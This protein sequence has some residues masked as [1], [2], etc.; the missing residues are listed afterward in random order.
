MAI[1]QS[2]IVIGE[3]GK[4]AAKERLVMIKA[5]K[6]IVVPYLREQGFKGSFPHYRRQNEENMDLITFQFNRYGGSF[7]VILAICPIE[8]L[9]MSWGEEIPANKVTAHDVSV[10]YRYRLT[11]NIKESNETWFNYENAKDE[12]DF[13]QVASKV[14]SLLHVSDRNWIKN[15]FI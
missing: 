9:T 8:G 5:L 7:V 4:M 13:E 12:E 1:K 11:E 15:L 6:K 10:N 14:M 2:Y 3:V